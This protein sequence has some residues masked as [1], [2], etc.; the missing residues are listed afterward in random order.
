M[1]NIIKEYSGIVDLDEAL[2]K[3]ISDFSLKLAMGHLDDAAR[4]RFLI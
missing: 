3:T 4:V 1:S 2:I